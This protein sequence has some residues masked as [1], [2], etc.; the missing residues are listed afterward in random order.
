[1]PPTQLSVM[2]DG[3]EGEE[4]KLKVLQLAALVPDSLT[5]ATQ[6]DPEI[7]LEEKFILMELEVEI[8]VAPVGK[9][10]K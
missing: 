6:T 9:I 4:A 3:V 2:D 10:H 1:M 7:K 8:P 5:A